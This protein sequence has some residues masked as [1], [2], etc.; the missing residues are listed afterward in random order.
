MTRLWT[1]SLKAACPRTRA[2]KAAAPKPSKP[3][4]PAAWYRCYVTLIDQFAEEGGKFPRFLRG[5]LEAEGLVYPEIDDVKPQYLPKLPSPLGGSLHYADLFERILANLEST[6][7]ELGQA[8]DR[9]R[10]DLFTL[11][12]GDLDTGLDASG[13]FTFWRAS[14]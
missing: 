4:D 7:R 14:P 12:N 3:P 5:F 13:Q 8:L 2:A 9:G 11:P 1:Q 6:W 10:P